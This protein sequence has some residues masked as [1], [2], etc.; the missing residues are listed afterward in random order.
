VFKV[1]ECD[2]PATT[3]QV[4][5]NISLPTLVFRV[6]VSKPP[7]SPNAEA[8]IYTRPDHAKFPEAT[9]PPTIG[10]N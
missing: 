7:V 2:K 8:K 10:T 1:T 5:I 3:E 6:Y 4:D 9:S